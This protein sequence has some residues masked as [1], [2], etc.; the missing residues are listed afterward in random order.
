M[1]GVT[2]YNIR[3]YVRHIFCILYYRC[4]ARVWYNEDSVSR[5][6]RGLKKKQAAPVLRCN[7]FCTK[8]GPTPVP[9]R[10]RST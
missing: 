1:R 4:S 5:L 10:E 8:D 6:P 2:C 9:T 7:A 3:S